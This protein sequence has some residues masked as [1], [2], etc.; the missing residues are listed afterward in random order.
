MKSSA[1]FYIMVLNILF[2][3]M[4]SHAEIKV[5]ADR[6]LN[7][8]TLTDFKFK[9]APSPS[10]SD[11]ATKAK[12]TIVDGRRDRNGGNV[13][14]LSDGRIPSEQDQPSENFFFNA[15]TEGGRD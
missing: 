2:F 12:F 9:S 14:K 8:Y 15:G 1:I 5:V 4:V 11:A 3:A 7:G 13:D 10:K 6:N